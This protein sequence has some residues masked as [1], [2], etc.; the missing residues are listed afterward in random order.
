MNL[1]LGRVTVDLQRHSQVR[2]HRLPR[3]QG[4]GQVGSALAGYGNHVLFDRCGDVE[5]WLYMTVEITR[6]NLPWRNFEEMGKVGAMKKAVR[7]VRI[8]Q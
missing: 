2:A 1:A 8:R 5:S 4:S 7:K 6:G 3:E